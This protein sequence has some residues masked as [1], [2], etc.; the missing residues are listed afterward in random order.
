M[1]GL[2]NYYAT[3]PSACPLIIPNQGQQRKIFEFFVQIIQLFL[4]FL[5][6]DENL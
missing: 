4:I 1:P 6:K 5:W 2:Y 3:P